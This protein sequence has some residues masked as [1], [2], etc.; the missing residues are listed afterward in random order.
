MELSHTLEV[1]PNL[2]IRA[3]LKF[4]DMKPHDELNTCKLFWGTLGMVTIPP[5]LLAVSPILLLV[6]IVG[7]VGDKIKDASVSRHLEAQEARRRL[8]PEELQAILDAEAAKKSSRAEKLEKFSAIA[9]AIW[10]KVQTPVTWFFRALFG[11]AV[12]GLLLF[13]AVALVDW[14]PT[15]PWDEILSLT[16]KV[17]IGAAVVALIGGVI[18]LGI[19]AWMKRHPPKPKLDRKKKPSV[20]KATLNSIH[21]HTCANIKIADPDKTV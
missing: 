6:F 10:F 17:L 3:F 18:Y 19:N 20:I 8:S 1:R 12:L 16:W 4:Y 2:F 7:T 11:F 15:L 14:L 9:G 5:F 21:D 13:G